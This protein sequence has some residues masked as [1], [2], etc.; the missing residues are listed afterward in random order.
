MH[1]VVTTVGFVLLFVL[2]LVS[3]V[4]GYDELSRIFCA[5]AICFTIGRGIY[6]WMDIRR[7]KAEMSELE[8]DRWLQNVNE[9]ICDTLEGVVDT[10]AGL[11]RAKQ[12]ERVH[13]NEVRDLDEEAAV[14]NDDGHG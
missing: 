3:L 6:A 11:L 1:I 5:G 10:E 8:L 9:G 13:P 14:P 4:F 2:T 7:M 12:S